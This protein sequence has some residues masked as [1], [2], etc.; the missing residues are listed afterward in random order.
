MNDEGDKHDLY[1]D[2]GK[3]LLQGKKSFGHRKFIF[4]LIFFL[5]ESQF[6]FELQM[7]VLKKLHPLGQIAHLILN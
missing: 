3:N 7:K 5:K 6:G 1:M 4:N 2:L